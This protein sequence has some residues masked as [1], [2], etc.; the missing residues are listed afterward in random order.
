MKQPTSIKK[1]PSV[2]V[3]KPVPVPK[4]LNEQTPIPPAPTPKPMINKS[5]PTPTMKKGMPA[6]FAKGGKTGSMV[7]KRIVTKKK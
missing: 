7:K 6:M 5:K 4:P 3:K 1:R 2:S